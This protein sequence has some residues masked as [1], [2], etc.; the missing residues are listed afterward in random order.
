ML[1]TVLTWQKARGLSSWG[2]YGASISY[3]IRAQLGHDAEER[4]RV[5]CE[6]GLLARQGRANGKC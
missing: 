5:G 3:A 4:S 1:L 2:A 6:G